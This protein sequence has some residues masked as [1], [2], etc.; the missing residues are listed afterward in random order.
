MLI[1]FY[2]AIGYMVEREIRLDE[3]VFANKHL[4]A[5]RMLHEEHLKVL[6]SR[7]AYITSVPMLKALV[8][9]HAKPRL[10]AFLERTLK[11]PN[12]VMYAV[13]DDHNKLLHASSPV[14]AQLKN[15][16][17]SSYLKPCKK[18][19]LIDDDLYQVLEVVIHSNDQVWGHLTVAFKMSEAVLNQLKR[20]TEFCEISLLREGGK[21]LFSSTLSFAARQDLLKLTS[22]MNFSQVDEGSFSFV[23]SVTLDDTNYVLRGV[24]LGEFGT[25]KVGYLLIHQS[26]ESMDNILMRVGR[27]FAL[28]GCVLLLVIFIIDIILVKHVL[29]PLDD[30]VEAISNKGEDDR[31]L[32]LKSSK[33]IEVSYLLQA[34]HR[35]LQKVGDKSEQFRRSETQYRNL[36]S[37][38][39]DAI[40]SMDE[41]QRICV[42]NHQAEYLFGYSDQEAK[43]IDLARI[44]SDASRFMGKGEF[45]DHGQ[46]KD[47]SFVPV[48][49]TVSTSLSVEDKI[50]HTAVIR[51]MR[52]QVKARER[53]QL[54]LQAIHHSSDMILISDCDAN[55]E[56]VNPALEK[57]TGYSLEELKGQKASVFNS[58]LESKAFYHK[59][60]DTIRRGDVWKGKLTNKCKD[61]SCYFEEMSISPVFASNSSTI[62]HYVAIKRDIS[63]QEH[64]KEQIEHTQRLESL[65]V[66]AGGIAHDFNN[67]LT[68][69]M[70]TASL[71]RFQVKE[72][73]ESQEMLDRIE[74]ASQHAADL[75]KQMLAYSG[76]GKFEIL[77]VN[78][79]D[80]V[81]SL[82]ELLEV[83]VE[84][85]IHMQLDLDDDLPMVNADVSQIQQ[86][87]MNLVINASEAA[88]K[89][90][91]FIRVET[92]VVYATSTMLNDMWL[93]EHLAEG[94]Y[95]FLDVV[96]NGCGMS[97]AVQQK[98]FDP[99]F[100]TK[101]TGRGLG[102][103]A[104]LGIVRGHSG[105]IRM[106]S[107]EGEG[108]SFTV[109]LPIHEEKVAIKAVEVVKKESEPCLG[110]GTV[111]L[112]DDEEVIR[113]VVKAMLETM[114]FDVI[115][116]CN[117]QQALEQ[118]TLHGSEV[119]LVLLDLT[120]PVMDGASCLKELRLF[121]KEVKVL[122]SSGYSSQEVGDLLHDDAH[123]G[124]MQKPYIMSAL[125]DKLQSFIH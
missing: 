57:V 50:L 85:T 33:T 115:L 22:K 14:F 101:F 67:L 87:V 1:S 100:T 31:V 80:L 97:E 39:N 76:K 10:S 54:L 105:A 69:I 110:S 119:V 86:I 108:T 63:E 16:C 32:N 4:E 73:L 66:L 51:D 20:M 28:F 27:F 88:N 5:V 56:Y 11:L 18:L 47:G 30:L 3:E 41:D 60:W 114:G 112:V 118:Y 123:V 36:V 43:D 103:S 58:G 23:P 109:F 104:I 90:H 78:L 8:A 95:V 37:D 71:L 107:E 117:G 21:N 44:F 83:S 121:D 79:S 17:Y 29:R 15:Q 12:D 55:I 82:V 19:M 42:W 91:G 48:E 35:M 52:A 102:M 113:K 2:L 62:L 77:P 46:H 99:F 40:I 38:A 24:S 70:G 81:S 34:I 89:N 53:D 72:D 124:F 92:G 65:G 49:V 106:Q 125:R 96:D 7:M 111:L 116:A 9:E 26:L 68:A 84:K 98:V 25:E 122:I 64:L 45:S 94:R 59:M 13:Y 75:C 93:D 120:M 61:Q 74:Q 6:M